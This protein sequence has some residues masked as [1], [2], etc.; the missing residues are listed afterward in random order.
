MNMHRRLDWSEL[1]EVLSSAANELR[2][3]SWLS[4]VPSSPLAVKPHATLCTALA[5]HLT[6][7]KTYQK[8]PMRTPFQFLSRREG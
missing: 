5:D 8:G 3:D 6:C 4:V 2:R 1:A 7:S